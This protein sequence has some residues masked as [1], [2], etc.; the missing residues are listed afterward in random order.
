[1]A[2]RR[3]RRAPDVVHRELDREAVLLDLRSGRYF[4]L[5]ATGAAVW[6]SLGGE[7]TS[8]DAITLAMTNRFKVEP[9]ALHQDLAALL[10]ALEG[11]GLIL[12][13]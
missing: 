7:W 8:I 4:A 9:A 1:V 11:A 10:A 6:E 13:D 2:T 12:R 3:I 5:N